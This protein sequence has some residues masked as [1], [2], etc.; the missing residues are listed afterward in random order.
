MKSLHDEL[1]K[2]ENAPLAI[3]KPLFYSAENRL[4]MLK[5][6]GYRS[7]VELINSRCYQHY[8]R[9]AGKALA[10][11]HQLPPVYGQVK[12][13]DDHL[14]ELIMPH[15]LALVGQLSEQGGR[16]KIIVDKLCDAGNRL[17]PQFGPVPLHRDFHLRQLFCGKR[18]V[19]LIDW[20]MYALGDPALDVGNFLVYLR[21]KIPTQS[22]SAGAAFLQGYRSLM[23]EVGEA[24]INLY[25]AL[26]YLRLACKAFRLKQKDWENRVDKLLTECEMRLSLKDS[27]S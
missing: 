11:L 18:K 3:P 2:R 24:N 26:T 21:V 9:L 12:T 4:L 25:Q 7:F 14:S 19:W 13:L 1:A 20:D 6:I 8:L 27:K 23:P 17:Q 16:V 22:L 5:W 15:P 10:L